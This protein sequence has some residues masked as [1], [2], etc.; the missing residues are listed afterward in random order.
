M[1]MD[2][3][4]ALGIIG[5]SLVFLSIIGYSIWRFISREDDE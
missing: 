1:A 2:I 4:T 3:K 5:Y